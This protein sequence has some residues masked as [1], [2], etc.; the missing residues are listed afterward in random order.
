[1]SGKLIIMAGLAVAFGATSYVGGNYYLESQT[2][3]LT[4]A[5]INELDAN[6]PVVEAVELAKVVVATSE[7]KFGEAINSSNIKVVDWPQDAFPEGA[8]TATSEVISDGNRRVLTTIFP[9]EPII[10]AK[11]TGENGRAGLSGIIAEGMRAVTVP[12]N[13]VNGVGGFIQPGDRV[14]ILLTKND[15]EDDSISSTTLMEYVKILSVDQNAGSRNETAQVASS[16]TI[17]T[18]ANGAK[19]IAWGL[20]VGT[21]SLTLRGA[22]DAETAKASDSNGDS[23]F[24]FEAEKPTRTSIKVVSG[25]NIKEYNVAIEGAKKP[26]NQNNNNN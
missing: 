11:I 17:E 6:R 19:K 10:T 2:Q 21:L 15:N 26:E 24:T 16:V 25:D 14:D 18:D 13:T 12:V 4:E 23:L 8:F 20:N 22:G 3:A 9:G 7:I 5:R 1:V